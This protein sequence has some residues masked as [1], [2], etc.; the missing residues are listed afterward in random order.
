[1]SDLL[2]KI[3]DSRGL[4]E[5]LVSKI[6]GFSGYMEKEA[7]RE[8]DRLLRTTIANR[9]GEQLSRVQGI[10]TQLLVGG[11]IEYVDDLQ[12]A[13]QRLTRF[14]DMVK[15]APMGY[16]GLFDAVKVKEKE[17]EQLYAFDYTLLDNVT[18]VAAGVDAVQNAVGSEALPS[19]IRGLVDL[20]AECN[21]TFERR[22]EVLLGQ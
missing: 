8:S 7:R 21:T 6:P 12:D 16:S 19:A 5:N 3:T 14:I 11:G 20:V 22:R 10:Q 4:L 2:K 1:M 18:R 13:A 9:Y 15:T 17:L